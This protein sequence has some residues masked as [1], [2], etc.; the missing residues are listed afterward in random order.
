MGQRVARV[1][2]EPREVGVL[3]EARDGVVERVDEL[4]EGPERAELELRVEV[5]ALL[6]GAVEGDDAVDALERAERARLD[7]RRVARAPAPEGP[8][9]DLDGV[10]GAVGLGAAAPDVGERA[11]PE[12]LHQVEVAREADVARRFRR[13]LF[14][15]PP[16]LRVGA[17]QPARLRNNGYNTTNSY[18]HS[19]NNNNNNNNNI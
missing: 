5:A 15:A 16:L 11:R 4:P 12:L 17:Q 10:L 14:H 2:E 13:R 7:E 9:R 6:P 18:N 1:A 19:N 8:L 3:L